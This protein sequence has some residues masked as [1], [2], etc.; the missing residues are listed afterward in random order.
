MTVFYRK[1]SRRETLKWVAAAIAATALPIQGLAGTAKIG[2]DPDLINPVIPWD[3]IMTARQKAITAALA[4]HIL[5]PEGDHPAPSEL[6]IEEFV[7]EWISAPYDDQSADCKLILG[8]LDRLETAAR[9]SGCEGFLECA[10]EVQ[11]QL[12]KEVASGKNH[13]D[14]RECFERLRYLVV[15]AYY[16]TPEGFKDIGYIGNVALASYPAPSQEILEILEREL[17]ELGL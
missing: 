12:L 16:T 9:G 8:G 3:R 2:S 10:P 14:D 7:D 17:K 6:G 11:V 5:P 13:A 4:D 1:I 15:G